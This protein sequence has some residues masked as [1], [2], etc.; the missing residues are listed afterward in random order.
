MTY[1]GPHWRITPLHIFHSRRVL[2]LDPPTPLIGHIAIG[3]I[4]RGT[5]II[6]VRPSTLCPHNCIYCSVDAGP[7]STTRQ[8]ELLADESHLAAHATAVAEYKGVMVEHLI[9]GVGEPLT[10]PG[11]LRLIALLKKHP[12][13]MR[14]ALETHGGFLT[15]RLIDRL[16]STGLDR[17]NLSLDTLDPDKAR[18]LSG[19]PWYDVGRVVKMIEHALDA[20]IDVVLTP[21]VVPGINEDDMTQLIELAR[22]L[23]L[24][25]QTGWPTGVLIQKYER[26]KY[27]RKPPGTREWSWAKFYRWLHQLEERTGYP[28]RP[29][30]EQLG[31]RPAPKLSTQ[32]RRGEK[33]T[34]H[35][36]A[37][38]WHK[39]ETLAVTRRGDRLAALYCR[40]PCRPGRKVQAVILRSRDNVI[41]AREI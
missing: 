35:A 33:I 30:M 2:R 39:G 27:G 6:Q 22:S 40:H 4:D 17:I 8:S 34:L 29:S 18:L 11:I 31:I 37:P 23:E 5:N 3:I 19:A 25:K 7:G 16:A 12:L 20:G 14:V 10:N 13:T 21:V 41:V 26:H 15:R 32:Y 9:D 36:A 1:E 28:L 38:G 24:G